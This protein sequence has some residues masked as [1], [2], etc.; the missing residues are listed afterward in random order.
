[1]FLEF[2]ISLFSKFPELFEFSFFQ[3][4]EKDDVS[5]RNDENM[6]GVIGSSGEDDEKVGCFF[7]N[8]FLFEIA[9][10]AV[11]IL[12]ESGKVVVIVH[13]NKYEDIKRNFL[14]TKFLT[15]IFQ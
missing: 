14:F 6:V 4:F 2:F 3:F 15:F 10:R 5:F 1:M 13:K 7:Q 12:G 11:V 9:E 8:A